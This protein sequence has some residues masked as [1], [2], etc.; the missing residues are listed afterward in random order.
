M[1]PL[2]AGQAYVDRSP[3]LGDELGFIPTD[4]QTLGTGPTVRVRGKTSGVSIKELY[5]AVPE[6]PGQD[7][8][9]DRRYP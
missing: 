7:R 8:G 2:H 1:I 4:E 6:G 3:G 5:P 9:E